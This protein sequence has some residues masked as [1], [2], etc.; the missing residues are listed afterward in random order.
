MKCYALDVPSYDREVA[1][2]VFEASF[3]ANQSAVTDVARGNK[4]I[5]TNGFDTRWEARE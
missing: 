1:P 5:C 2:F 4:F 3:L